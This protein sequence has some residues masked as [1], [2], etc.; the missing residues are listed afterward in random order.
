[1]VLKGFQPLPK[2]VKLKV[3]LELKVQAKIRYINMAAIR[4]FTTT[5]H[6][7]ARK[8]EKG[9]KRGNLE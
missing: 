1:M 8:R 3:G 5:N 6:N 9:I 7:L 4:L 2:P